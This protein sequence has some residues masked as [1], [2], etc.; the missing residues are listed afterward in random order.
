MNNLKTFSHMLLLYSDDNKGYFP[1]P[2]NTS[3]DSSDLL[4]LAYG[5]NSISSPY[6]NDTIG[7]KLSFF[8]CPESSSHYENI[9]SNT[10]NL[11][12]SY[13]YTRGKDPALGNNNWQRG[14]VQGGWSVE[15]ENAE[16]WSMKHTQVNDPSTA[17][18]MVE[19]DTD[20]SS[21]GNSIVGYNN[22]QYILLNKLRDSIEGNPNKH[23]KTFSTNYLYVDGHVALR[24]FPSMAANS[25][26]DLWTSDHMTGTEFDCQD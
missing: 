16:P 11:K 14:V 6:R 3:T 13:A 18:F 9:P 20:Q 17:A 12:R 2:S 25:G 26:T 7:N 5:N 23:A 15:N 22:N 10:S 21:I 19:I 24:F 4:I 8:N 1:A